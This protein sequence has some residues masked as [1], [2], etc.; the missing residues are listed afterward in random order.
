MCNTDAKGLKRVFRLLL[1]S[2]AVSS[3]H[4]HSAFLTP[5]AFRLQITAVPIS[6]KWSGSAVWYRDVMFMTTCS[7]NGQRPLKATP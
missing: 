2:E 5:G 1:S 6:E 7:V 4:R 3:N